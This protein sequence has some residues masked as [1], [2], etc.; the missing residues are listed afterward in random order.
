MCRVLPKLMP[1]WLAPLL[2][3][4][5]RP[6]VLLP[7]LSCSSVNWRAFFS[8]SFGPRPGLPKFGACGKE[9]VRVS[10]EIRQALCK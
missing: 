3:P 9:E 2:L 7:A 4:I 8:D 5:C 10:A 1:D 6:M